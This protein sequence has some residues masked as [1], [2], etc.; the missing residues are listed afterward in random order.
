MFKHWKNGKK[1]KNLFW[2]I[3]QFAQL[4][5][6]DLRFRRTVVLDHPIDPFKLHRYTSTD[7]LALNKRVTKI[8]AQY[9]ENSRPEPDIL[10]PRSQKIRNRKSLIWDRRKNLSQFRWAVKSSQAWSGAGPREKCLDEN[11]FKKKQFNYLNLLE[12]PC[13]I[14][15][16]HLNLQKNKKKTI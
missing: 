6:C 16:N 11:P 7:S 3:L 4:M 8:F 15:F 14:Q 1:S 2:N 9:A 13:K 12:K 10:H 5:Y